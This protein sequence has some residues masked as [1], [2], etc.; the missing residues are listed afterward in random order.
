[1]QNTTFR[2]LTLLILTTFLLTA[3]SPATQPAS[4]ASTLKVLAAETFL[5]DI[6]QNVAGERVQVQSLLPLG[7]DPHTFEPTPQDVKK[8]AESNVLI[9][10]GA[11]F[12]KWAEKTLQ[13]AGGE[14]L[15]IEAAAGLTMR[16]PKLE[17]HE[18][19]QETHTDHHHEG[20]PHF[21]FDPT[22]VIKYVENIRDGLIAADPAGKDVYTTN[23]AA[24]I[25]QLN[26]LDAW[27]K[28][29]VEQIPPQRRL[30]ITDHE[31]FGY[32]ADRYGFT[33]V[34]AI[35]PNATTEAAPSA[36]ALAGLIEQIRETG[37][38][39]IFLET[40]RSPQLAE[41]IAAETNT[42]VVTDIYTHSLTEADGKAPTYIDMMKHNVTVIVQ[43]LK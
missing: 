34:G 43:A 17:M 14:R 30:L 27:I 18:H 25:T 39:A 6:A 24:Y 29:Q 8:I 13:N 12:E 36:Q 15:V 37:A 21:W 22:L 41:Q 40:G 7:V 33:L 35:I 23:A 3:C 31:T 1:M 38:P 4:S 2:W 32:F 19:E 9:L 5:A 42:T 10:N 11:G 20:D 16:E 26:E 28:T